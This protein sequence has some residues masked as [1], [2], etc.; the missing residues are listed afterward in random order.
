MVRKV[1]LVSRS[2]VD[3]ARIFVAGGGGGNGV[4]SFRREKYVARGGPDGGDGGRGGDVVLRGERDLTTLAPLAHQVR[5]AADRGESGRGANKHGKRGRDLIVG[6][7]LGTVVADGGGSFADITRDGQTVVAARGGK[8]GLGNVHFTTSTQ[9]APRMA[10]KGDPGQERW[11]TLELKIIGDVGLVGEPNAGKSSLLAAMSAARPEIAP[12]PF[13]T[14]SPVLGVAEVGDVAFVVVDIP[15]LI[16]GAH[17]GHGLGDRFLRH[18]ERTRVL[19]HVLDASAPDPVA[20]YQRVRRELE[21]FNPQLI[22]KPTLVAANKMDLAEA[23]STWESVRRHLSEAGVREVFLMSAVTGDGVSRL[24]GAL[25]K[26]LGVARREA[27]ADGQERRVYRLASEETSFVVEREG[28]T[29]RV[30][31]REPE[32][33][34][35]TADMESDEGLADLQRRMERLGVF[36]ALEQAGVK[37]GDTVHVGAFDLE[38]T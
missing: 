25:E 22:Q 3:E 2:V 16:E 21:L 36:R 11:L 30:V 17:D 18:V 19:V 23:Q 4:V 5:F 20:S 9:Q 27:P 8:G 34:V 35:V 31:G 33:I 12:Y 7:P 6:V 28:G 1:Q 15:G 26:R 32:R 24:L 38:W 14:L 37:P 10:R 13:T 29:Y